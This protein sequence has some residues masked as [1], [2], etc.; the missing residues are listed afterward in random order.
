MLSIDVVGVYC[1]KF[2]TYDLIDM[3][4]GELVD[5]GFQTI[6]EMQVYCEQYGYHY[7]GLKDH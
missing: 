1:K 3:Y 5:G 4:S 7:N 6:P 2:F